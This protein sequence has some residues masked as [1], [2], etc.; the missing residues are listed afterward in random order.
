MN[1]NETSPFDNEQMLLHFYDMTESI[2]LK[3]SKKKFSNKKNFEI[4]F[5][6]QLIEIDPELVIVAFAYKKL[7]KTYKIEGKTFIQELISRCGEGYSHINEI[8]LVNFLNEIIIQ[9]KLQIEKEAF[10]RKIVWLKK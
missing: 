5:N 1:Q 4:V 10:K 8:V 7:N 9:K 2:R 3:F 6:N